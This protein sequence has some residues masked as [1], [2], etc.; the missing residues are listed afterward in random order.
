MKNK[1]MLVSSAG[2]NLL[3]VDV[4]NA[5]GNVLRT[6][7]EVVDSS[8][9]VTGRFGS[10]EEAKSFI[11]LLGNLEQNLQQDQNHRNGCLPF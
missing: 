1:K 6:S 8:E 5:T 9:D 2:F 7:Y 10:L 4:L 11:Q 3:Q